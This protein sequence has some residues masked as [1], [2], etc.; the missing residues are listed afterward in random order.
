MRDTHR[1]YI[2]IETCSKISHHKILLGLPEY[3]VDEL[4]IEGANAGDATLW[5]ESTGDERPGV[6]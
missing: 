3:D 4:L 6:Q 2:I 5:R 1:A